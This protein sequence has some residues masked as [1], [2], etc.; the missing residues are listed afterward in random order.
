LAKSV[1]IPK[2]GDTKPD[3]DGFHL[4]YTVRDGAGIW[5][6]EAM[7]PGPRATETAQEALEEIHPVAPSL[8]AP[9]RVALALLIVEIMIFH[10]FHH[11]E[12]RTIVNLVRYLICYRQHLLTT[13]TLELGKEAKD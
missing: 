7:T 10:H 11:L 12:E 5:V 4:R 1:L 9:A 8:P 6:R 13:T 3:G 2:E